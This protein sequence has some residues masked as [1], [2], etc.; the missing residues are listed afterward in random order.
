MSIFK[1]SEGLCDELMKLTRDFWWGDEKE[2]RKVHWMCWEKVTKRKGQGGMGF[3][4]L[5]LFNQALLARQAWRLIAFPDSLCARLLKAK[6]YPFRELTDT[7]FVQN[8]SPGWQGIMHGLE[9]LKKGFIW[10]IGDGKKI[11]IWRDNWVPRGDMKVTN[12]VNN[13]RIRRVAELINHNS[14]T[15][16]EDV[17]RFVFHPFDAEEILKIRLPS[18]DTEDLVSWTLEKHVVFSVRSDYNLALDLRNPN[19]PS[20]NTNLNGDRGL[21]KTI[22]N[23]NVPPEVKIFTWKLATNSLAVQVN[24]SRRLPRVL[25]TCSICG[26]EDETSYHATMRCTKA[27]ALRQGLELVWKLPPEEELGETG[28]DWVLVLLDSLNQDMRSKMMFIW[29]RSWHHRNNIIF[30]KGDASVDNSIRFLQNYLDIVQG[31]SARRPMVDRKGKAHVCQTQRDL[32]T[33][34]SERKKPSWEK[35]Q[36]GWMKCN[37][38]A[39]FLE[40]EKKGH[41]GA[42]LRD[43]NGAVICSAWGVIP[44]CRSAAMGEGI[45]CLQG[46]EISLQYSSENLIIETDCSAV[47]EAFNNENL[48]RTDLGIV[49][50]EFRLKKPPDRQVSL[51]KVDRNCNMVAH[52]ICQMSRRELS[53]GVLLSAVPTCVSRSAWKDCNQNPVD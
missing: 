5:R 42:V 24:R 48:N 15:W 53:S 35:P 6:Y 31:I 14:R 40:T 20:S 18:F 12:N 4:D 11:R 51:V 36:E 45:A 26:V 7:A 25:P 10:R 8:T 47:L 2:K 29:W 32:S 1:F 19:P 30:D 27:R 23:S 33:K 13:S 9:L 21:W 16:K 43:L 37:V 52:S 17:V 28:Q 34:D 49:A 38:D 39:S 3:R 46:L 22:W 44:H 41:W 50:K